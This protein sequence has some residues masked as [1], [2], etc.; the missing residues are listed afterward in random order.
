MEI[1]EKILAIGSGVVVRSDE[2]ICRG[3]DFRRVTMIRERVADMSYDD[4]I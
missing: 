1:E 2:W 3:A 4:G